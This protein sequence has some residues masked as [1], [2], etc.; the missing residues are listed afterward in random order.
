MA[1]IIPDMI[2]WI[3]LIIILILDGLAYLYVK[4]SK[5]KNIA[6]VHS[7]IKIVLVIFILIPNTLFSGFIR[8]ISTKTESYEIHFVG[9]ND[10][11]FESVQ[12]LNNKKI[13][14]LNDESSKIGYIYPKN[15]I[16]EAEIKVKFVEYESYID[17]IQALLNRK[18]DLIVLP[19][20]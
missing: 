3:F 19:G 2:R 15:I 12:E 10:T 16:E 8:Q 9:L 18:V 14:I 20:G 13:G 5:R 4:R 1:P 6:L 11:K 7:V 17:S